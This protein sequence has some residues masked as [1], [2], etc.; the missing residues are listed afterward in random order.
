MSYEYLLITFKWT[1]ATKSKFVHNFA[2]PQ[3]KTII[4]RRQLIYICRIRLFVTLYPYDVGTVH[5]VNYSIYN[6]NS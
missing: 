4:L 2:T 5:A 6:T 1:R 3:I